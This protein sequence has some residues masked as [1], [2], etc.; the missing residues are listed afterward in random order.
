GGLLQVHRRAAH[1]PDDTDPPP[2]REEGLGGDQGHRPVLDYRVRPGAG[3]ARDAEGEVMLLDGSKVLVVGAGR[4]GVA[5]ARLAAARG[6]QVTL[7][8][9]RPLEA[10]GGAVA[11]MPGVRLELAGHRA[12]TFVSADLIVLS[13]GV[14]P[15]LPR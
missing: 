7:T 8:D 13:A 12:A 4:S 3:R 11:G 2:L 9:S 14:P 10:L 5:A 6:A 15:A 1:L